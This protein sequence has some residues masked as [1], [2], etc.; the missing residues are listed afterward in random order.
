MATIKNEHIVWAY[1]EITDKPGQVV[2]IVGLT[3]Q[4]LKY[5]RNTPGQ[6]LLVN[7]PGDGFANVNQI[8][9]FYERDKA[10]LK[11]TLRKAGVTVSEVN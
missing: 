7:P 8:V 6:T 4:G 10:T 2:V 3:D 5:I 9:V 11:E 1:G